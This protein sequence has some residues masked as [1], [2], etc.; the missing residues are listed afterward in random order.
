MSDVETLVADEA[1][2]AKSL[3]PVCI[4]VEDTETLDL[5]RQIKALRI[6][7]RRAQQD[8]NDRYQAEADA[9]NDAFAKRNDEVWA[10]I[11]ARTGIDP[12]G[13][14][15]I[16]GEYL[17]QHG[18]A[19]IKTDDCACGAEHGMSLADLLG[20]LAGGKPVLVGGG[21]DEPGP[22]QH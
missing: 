10:K 4:K 17:D 9:L 19:F 11:Y 12:N 22:T 18:L 5:V 3:E 2:D 8:L 6:D 7:S 16:D 21:N 13:S 14:Y 15:T 1:A 20:S